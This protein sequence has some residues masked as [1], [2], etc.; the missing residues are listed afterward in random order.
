VGVSGRKK[1]NKYM[2]VLILLAVSLSVISVAS[3]TICTNAQ[4]AGLSG[5]IDGNTVSIT[6]NGHKA[7]NVGVAVYMKFDENIDNQK[8]FDSI[9]GNVK[10]GETIN[11]S[12]NL[13]SCKYQ[14]DSFCGPVIESLSNARYNNRKIAWIH[15]GGPDYCDNEIP[16]FSIVAAFVAVI[17]AFG[18]FIARRK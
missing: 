2:F 9:T 14:L 10:P 7:Q 13:P 1:M 4:S 17:G 12:V 6:N 15:L 3:A 8:I 18:I 11:L 16:E 5:S